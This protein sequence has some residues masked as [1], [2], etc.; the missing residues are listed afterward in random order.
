MEREDIKS[1]IESLL[2]VADGPLTIQRLGEVLEGVEQKDSA[3][4]LDELQAEMESAGAGF[5]WS[6]WPAVTS[7]ERRK[8]MRIG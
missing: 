1:I 4:D 6:R 7:C 3:G 2:F 5:G 8:S